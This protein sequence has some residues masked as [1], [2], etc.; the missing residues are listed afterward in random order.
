MSSENS[1]RVKLVN[2]TEET[3]VFACGD[4]VVPVLDADGRQLFYEDAFGKKLPR[5]RVAEKIHS[6]APGDTVELEI[7]YCR[8]PGIAAD[9]RPL[10]SFLEREGLSK[11][12]VPADQAK[13][14]AKAPAK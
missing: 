14:K 13:A 3:V 8:S 2:V 6:V 4:A 7:G 1:D 10:A 9:G 5:R 12:L 11:R